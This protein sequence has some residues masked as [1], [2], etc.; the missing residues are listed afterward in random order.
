[1]F[2]L[3]RSEVSVLVIY[4]LLLWSQ[5]NDYLSNSYLATVAKQLHYCYG[6]CATMVTLFVKLDIYFQ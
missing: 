3:M 5:S 6:S 4:H 1:M 2:K